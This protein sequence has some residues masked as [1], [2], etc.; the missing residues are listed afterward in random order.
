[1]KIKANHA[2][3]Y[4]IVACIFLVIFL[5]RSALSEGN[6]GSLTIAFFDVGQGDSI[7]IE[8]PSGK[9]VLID[10]GKDRKVLSELSSVM[11][12][13]DRSIDLVIGTHPDADHIGGLVDV[14]RDYEISVYMDS[15]LQKDT[16]FYREIFNLVEEK[17]ISFV[18]ANSGQII[19]LGEGAFLQIFFPYENFVSTDA[20]DYSVVAKL[21]Y[22]ETSAL[23]T[24][25]SPVMI[26]L[27]LVDIFGEQLESDILKIGHHGSK[28]STADSFLG[29]ANPEYGII[30][31][32]CDNSYGHPN[33]IVI[34]RLQEDKVEILETCER[35]TVIF[36]SGGEKLWLE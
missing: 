32:G 23:L 14:L 30:S 13:Y 5:W 19:S 2:R 26:E 22:G 3:W 21:I 4:L 25:D 29:A 20:N 10:G 16:T 36:H 1:M 18:R 31:A 17:E 34:E 9:Q 11:P 6:S 7:F 33:D 27:Q 15:G 24:G 28:T 8:S 35:G 12:F